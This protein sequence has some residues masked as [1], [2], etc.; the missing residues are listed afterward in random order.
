MTSKKIVIS[1]LVIVRDQFIFSYLSLAHFIQNKNSFLG[2][3]LILRY[4]GQ[5]IVLADSQYLDS[6]I[7]NKEAIES[8][9]DSSKIG[10]KRHLMNNAYE[11][12]RAY[13]VQTKQEEIFS[14]Q[15]WYP[16]ARIFR[17]H[18][19]HHIVDRIIDWPKNYKDKGI[20]EVSWNDKIIKEGM[21]GNDIKM[22]EVEVFNLVTEMIIFV[23]KVL[24]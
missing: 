24:K 13:C 12:I 18:C 22:N 6:V 15:S 17:N 21:L 7:S 3:D 5:N 1:N 4:S 11:I 14:K 20:L 2:I 8:V 9:T 16:F 10:F 23:D 19:S